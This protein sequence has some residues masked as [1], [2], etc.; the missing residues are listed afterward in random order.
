EDEEINALYDRGRKESLDAFEKVYERLGTKFDNYF[1]EG[2]EGRNGEAIARGLLQK[3]IL[4]E[5]DG[6]IIFPGE[7][8]GL[9]TRVFINSQGLPTYE[10]KELGLN[11]EKFKL[12]PDLDQSIIVTANEQSDYFKVLLKVFDLF[13]KNIAGKTKHISHGMMRFAHGKMSS[14][15]GNV[16]SGTGLID[17]IKDM[18]MEKMG[19]ES[20]GDSRHALS[21]GDQQSDDQVA[22]IVAIGAI[23][24]TI[25]RQAIGGD[26]IFD[27]VKSISFEGDSGPYLQYSTVRAGAVLKK[28]KDEGI[29]P[30]H[31][32][33]RIT[34][35]ENWKVHD[36]ERLLIRFGEIADNACREFAPQYV[37]NYLMALAGEYNSFYAKQKIVDKSDPLSPYYVTI[38]EAFRNVIV[39]GL[40]LLGIGVPER[41]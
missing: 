16:I 15:K 24:Y 21:K 32:L 26:I 29:D 39:K 25:L 30:E 40:W 34:F 5:S 23:K 3:G 6:A 33:S 19:Q 12:Y 14:R 20:S 37:A 4:E 22:D 2:K 8:Y 10:T 7:K 18:V 13:E 31:D 36:I 11:V 35:P 17:E 38:T 41:M 27:S 28:A 1:F 9:H